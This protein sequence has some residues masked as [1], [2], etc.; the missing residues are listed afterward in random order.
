MLRPDLDVGALSALNVRLNFH[1]RIK[2]V[3]VALRLTRKGRLLF[4]PTILAQQVFGSDTLSF[5][6]RAKHQVGWSSSTMMVQS[7]GLLEQR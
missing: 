6:V 2:D 4:H 5:N 7:I 3:K 1:I